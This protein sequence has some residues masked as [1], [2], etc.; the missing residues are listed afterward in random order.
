MN[1]LLLSA[2]FGTRLKPLTNILPKGLMPV[3]GVPLIEYW[4]NP[5]EE[6]TN[7]EEI[8]I[9]THYKSELFEQYFNLRNNK[10]KTTL[11]HEDPILGTGGT[12]KKNSS[13]FDNGPLMVVHADNLSI[14]SV[15]D[16]I[17]SHLKRPERTELTMMLFET[18]QPRQCGIVELDEQ[19]RVVQFHEKVENPPGNLANAAVYIFE[20]ILQDE[21]LT[22]K[23]D[24]IDLS[25]E[26]LPN[27]MG[28]IN[29][30]L[31]SNYH[32]DIGN[33]E[34]LLNA[35]IE[36]Y[37][38]SF[39]NTGPLMS[40]VITKEKFENELK[41]ALKNTMNIELRALI[42]GENL[43]A[44]NTCYYLSSA[45]ADDDSAVFYEKHA[46]TLFIFERN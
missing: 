38:Q 41:T 40:Q 16:F 26:I 32:R 39:K 45:S 11:I 35:Q 18:D 2:G 33:I 24:F 21:L 5:L 6:C 1:A 23:K 19:K 37:F 29:T 3:N 34:S 10:K 9:N 15:E 44:E 36:V 8:F 27:K 12:I 4:M 22:I 13:L 17:N 42:P 14:F 25:T 28:K 43:G 31:N 7:I 46:R 20:N 30:F